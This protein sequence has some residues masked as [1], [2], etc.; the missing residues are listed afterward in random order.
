[1]SRLRR[2][3]LLSG[4]LG[5]LISGLLVITAVWIVERG[6]LLPLLPYPIAI[7]L[8]AVILAGFSLAEIPVMVF[9]MRRL[10]IERGGN[11]GALFSLNALYVSFASVY[12]VPI[13]LLTGSTGWGL[14]ISALALVRFVSSL[15]FVREQSNHEPASSS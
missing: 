10:A 14:A 3:L 6:I 7:L 11:Q 2:N 12:G 8:F 4:L 13:V 1:V 15:L 9:A 5:L